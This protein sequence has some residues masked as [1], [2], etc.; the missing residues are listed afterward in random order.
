MKKIFI[1]LF[2][3]LL[4]S[5]QKN[6]VK[7]IIKEENNIIT[8]V[9]TNTWTTNEDKSTKRK[10]FWDKTTFSY[11]DSRN[12][13]SWNWIKI[14]ENK[15]EVK[16]LENSIQKL[17]FNF[18]SYE[19]DLEWQKV[20]EYCRNKKA[21]RY[22]FY[23]WYLYKQDRYIFLQ[24]DKN[25]EISEVAAQNNFVTTTVNS[26][27]EISFRNYWDISLEKY[28]TEYKERM[29]YNQWFWKKKWDEIEFNA[30]WVP[31]TGHKE[32]APSP[33][34]EYYKILKEPNLNF[35]EWWLTKWWKLSVCFADIYYNYNYI[36]NEITQTKICPF[37]I[38]D[39]WEIK[40]LQDCFK[41]W[42]DSQKYRS[43]IWE[44]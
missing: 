27:W 7:N 25:L 28:F 38:N 17:T 31:M 37:F 26:S 29:R 36:K 42:N 14:F 9:V 32:T 20:I 4:S 21:D 35:C 30:F 5:C 44:N 39:N 1:F 6:E 13:Y 19:D 41:I 33:I 23:V 8:K 3:I 16:M 22:I 18:K 34:S 10:I 12:K 2:L 40:Q 24:Y 15:K 11:C 43:I